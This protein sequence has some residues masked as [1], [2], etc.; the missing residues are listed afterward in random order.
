MALIQLDALSRDLA[1]HCPL[2]VDVT[3]RTY[4]APLRPTGRAR[5]AGHPPQTFAPWQHALLAYLRSGQQVVVIQPRETGI[6][7][8]TLEHVL[9]GP[10]IGRADGYVLHRV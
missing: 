7:R 3:G 5:P 8:T 9:R 6:S 1:D 4:A 10:T 2:W